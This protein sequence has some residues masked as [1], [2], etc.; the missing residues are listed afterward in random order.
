MSNLTVMRKHT[1]GDLEPSLT[2]L[3]AINIP[4]SN[5][6]LMRWA[7]VRRGAEVKELMIRTFLECEFNSSFSF[8]CLKSDTDVRGGGDV[9]RKL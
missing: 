5:G 4:A 6:L 9:R 7:V 2:P 8:F 1:H 3:I